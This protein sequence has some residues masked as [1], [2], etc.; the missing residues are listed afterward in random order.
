M[1]GKKK[2]K[3]VRHDKKRLEKADRRRKKR[4]AEGRPITGSAAKV[5]PKLAAIRSA[6]ES[7]ATD[8]YPTELGGEEHVEDTDASD[9]LD[10]P[11]TPPM[12]TGDWKRERRPPRPGEEVITT[13]VRSYVPPARTAAELQR[14]SG[15]P[16]HEIWPGI[17]G[18][19]I[20]KPTGEIWIMSP[21]PRDNAHNDW[22]LVVAFLNALHPRCRI[23][24][25]IWGE[26]QL[27]LP[28]LGWKSLP[29]RVVVTADHSVRE[30]DVWYPPEDA[31]DLKPGEMEIGDGKSIK[32]EA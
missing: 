13:S 32:I 23:V 24:N 26:L 4:A 8:E 6:E 7:D 12:D 16:D 31:R 19:C 21:E 15:P 5:S 22:N 3:K 28:R 20:D 1:S 25:C 2:Q 14:Y 27:I 17:I 30:I 18:Y 11:V 10:A 9:I 29:Q